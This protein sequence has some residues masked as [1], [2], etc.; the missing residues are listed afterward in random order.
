MAELQTTNN[1]L[2]A[3]QSS[4]SSHN[5]QP[6]R[7]TKDKVKT[8]NPQPEPEVYALVRE[9]QTEVAEMKQ[10]VLASMSTIKPQN[11]K[12]VAESRDTWRRGCRACRDKG[13]GGSCV[14]CFKCSQLGHISRGCRDPRSRET[15]GGCCRG[16]GSEPATT[17][18]ILPLPSL[19]AGRIPR[20]KVTDMHRL[21]H[22][23]LLFKVVSETPLAGT[24]TPL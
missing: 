23:N 6:V 15:A 14:H 9:L 5:M 1:T 24:Q 17:V 20:Q 7:N 2:D 22:Y 21:F 4:S 11:L 18:S 3:A 12:Q 19:F 8:T 13:E 10:M 16:T